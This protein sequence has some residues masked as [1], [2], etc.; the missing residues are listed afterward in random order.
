MEEKHSQPPLMK[1]QK[2]ARQPK[3]SKSS[4]CLGLYERGLI[5]EQAHKQWANRQRERQEREKLREC[6]HQPSINHLS[7]SMVSDKDNTN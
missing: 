5:R 1:R 4:K 7:R 2:Q 3:G 6:T